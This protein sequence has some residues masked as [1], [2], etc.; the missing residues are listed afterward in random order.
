M[1]MAGKSWLQELEMAEHCF[2][3]GEAEGWMLSSACSA[4]DPG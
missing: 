2:G 4:Q 3:S 1:A